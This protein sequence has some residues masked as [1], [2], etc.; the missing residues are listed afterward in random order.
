M[1]N[2][3]IRLRELAQALEDEAADHA[4]KILKLNADISRLR[5]R[6][7]N[8][9][10]GCKSESSFFGAHVE[11]GDMRVTFSWYKGRPAFTVRRKLE[12]GETGSDYKPVRVWL[13]PDNDIEVLE[14]W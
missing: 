12:R 13:T 11:M 3:R 2:P 6:P 14:E 5:C 1:S 9:G 8:I 10:H 7:I 4:R